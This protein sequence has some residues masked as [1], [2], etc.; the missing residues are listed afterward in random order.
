MNCVAKIPTFAKKL[1]HS[2]CVEAVGTY[3]TDCIFD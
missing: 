1:K 2:F 3:S